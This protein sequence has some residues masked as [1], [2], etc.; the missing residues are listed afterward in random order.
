M[1]KNKQ[2]EIEESRILSTEEKDWYRQFYKQLQIR[3]EN[4][5]R[6]YN[7]VNIY[8]EEE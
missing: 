4:K 2:N 1:K 7:G 8:D 6:R 3:K 5:R